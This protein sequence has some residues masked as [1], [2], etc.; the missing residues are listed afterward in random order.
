MGWFDN[1]LGF[2]KC[3]LCINL[4][5][6]EEQCDG[7]NL[8]GATCASVLGAGLLFN[9]SIGEVMIFNRSLTPQEINSIYSA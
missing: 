6:K 8:G 5:I 1:R 7:V 3:K 4:W 9:G 2:L